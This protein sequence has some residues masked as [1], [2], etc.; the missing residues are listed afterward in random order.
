M[1]ILLVHLGVIPVK[2][3]GGT[4]RVV[5]YLGQELVKM[6]HRVTYLVK[7]GSQCDFANIRFIDPS[8]PIEEQIPD[9]I[10]VVHLSYIPKE[11]L[12][13][14]YICNLHGNLNDQRLLDKNTVFVSRNHANRFGSDSFV[15]NG[16]NWD[17]YGSPALEHKRTYFHFLGE[18]A[19]RLK[20][21]K[22]AISVITHTQK[23]KLSVLGGTRLNFRMGFRFTISPRIK[24]YGKVGGEVKNNLLLGSKGLIFPV[25]WNEPFGIAITE[26]LYFGCPVFGTPYGSLP[27]LITKDVGFLSNNSEELR[28]AV[29]NVDQFS[30]KNCHLYA[31]EHFN[32]RKMAEAYL[33][34]YTEVLNGRTLNEKNPCLI[35]IQQEKFLDWK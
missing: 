5:W 35:N 1:N 24:F 28:Q 30:P 13:K 10:D 15:Y 23:E 29:E 6:G 25:R 11:P 27:E 14:P 19:W 18:A 33:S 8:L 3:Y 17:D 22:G 21:V 26:S 4:E 7:E 34:K 12:K 16:M 20:N 31:L 9:D 32:S 2:T